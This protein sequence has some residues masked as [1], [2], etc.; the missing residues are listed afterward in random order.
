MTTPG[1]GRWT[2]TKSRKVR[3]AW[4]PR[5]LPIASRP[6]SPAPGIR[7]PRICARTSGTATAPVMWGSGTVSDPACKESTRS[8]TVSSM[9]S[10]SSAI[11]T[12]AM[13]ETIRVIR[14]NAL[15]RAAAHTQ[16]GVGQLRPVRPEAV[17]V[18]P[19]HDAF[20]AE[21]DPGAAGTHPGGL[22]AAGELCALRDER[23]DRFVECVDL[24][25]QDRRQAGLVIRSR[26][27]RC[28]QH[29]GH[30]V[31]CSFGGRERRRQT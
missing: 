16:D 26:R 9:T 12:S 7:V 2:T 21:F 23:D 22:D 28:V 14:A 19:E 31:L 3:P 4:S 17:A 15:F 27:V 24:S 10:A 30:L 8:G 29:G 18:R 11:D 5:Q 13:E 1:P 20:A 6:G 25:A